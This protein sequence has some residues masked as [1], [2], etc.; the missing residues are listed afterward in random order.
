MAKNKWFWG[1]PGLVLLTVAWYFLLSAITP[2]GQPPLTR[3]TSDDL[4]V[5][6]FNRAAS[7]V[8]MV[9]LLSPT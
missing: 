5:S 2:N 1:L 7:N 3:L 8:R 6:R 4:F 9:L